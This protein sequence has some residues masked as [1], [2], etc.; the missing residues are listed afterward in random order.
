MKLM[1]IR[2]VVFCGALLLTCSVKAV[3]R[4]TTTDPCHASRLVQK[5][6][7]T[8]FD[9]T[10]T[11]VEGALV[12]VAGTAITATTDH[13][14]HFTLEADAGATLAV[15][16]VVE[17]GQASFTYPFTYIPTPGLE[18]SYGIFAVGVNSAGYA[19]RSD[20]RTAV[21]FRR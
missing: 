19:L 20:A 12:K 2:F 9:N 7:G 8:V 4:K 21:F 16:G 14:G 3:P 10:H 13:N 15:D 18:G 1:L 17:G 11:P 5:Y 6:T